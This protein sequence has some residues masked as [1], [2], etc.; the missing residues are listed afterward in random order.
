MRIR[1]GWKDKNGVLKDGYIDVPDETD[2][3]EAGGLMEPFKKSDGEKLQ[4]PPV[5][6]PA[7]DKMPFQRRRKKSVPNVQ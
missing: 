6:P 4:D 5:N 2:I 3:K 1:T 7:V